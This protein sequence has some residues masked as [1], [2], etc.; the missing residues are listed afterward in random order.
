MSQ[1][2]YTRKRIRGTAGM[3][4]KE[5]NR[6]QQLGALHEVWTLEVNRNPEDIQIGI[7]IKKVP[8][9][10]GDNLQ[11]EVISGYTAKITDREHQLRK[12]FKYLATAHCMPINGDLERSVAIIQKAK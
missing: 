11:Y 1:H 6:L 7:E 8:S 12:E 4:E 5:L 9:A 10:T 3:L 2:Q